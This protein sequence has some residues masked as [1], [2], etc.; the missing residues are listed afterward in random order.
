MF[1]SEIS[2]KN[3]DLKIINAICPP[4]DENDLEYYD[5]VFVEEDSF[6]KLKEYIVELD[7]YN[8]SDYWYNIVTRGEYKWRNKE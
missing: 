4:E 3:Y 8:Y 2:L 7:G 1:V 5:S 6:D